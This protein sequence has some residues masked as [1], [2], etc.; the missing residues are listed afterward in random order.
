M[1]YLKFYCWILGNCVIFVGLYGT[2]AAVLATGTV[3]NQC[4]GKCFTIWTR[5][6]CL[7]N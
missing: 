1:I 6:G 5:N 4:P 3:P 2:L 7:T